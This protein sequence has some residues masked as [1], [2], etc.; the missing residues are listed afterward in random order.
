[1]SQPDPGAASQRPH[2][3]S[4]V[5]NLFLQD[6]VRGAQESTRSRLEVVVASPGETPASALAAAGVFLGAPV[7]AS[8]VEDARMRWSAATHFRQDEDLPAVEEVAGPLPAKRW[9]RGPR[10]RRAVSC[11]HLGCLGQDKLG[12]LE[13]V[14]STRPL[15]GS[16]HGGVDYLVWCLLHREVGLMV[17]AY[18]L[19]RLAEVLGPQQVRVLI[20]PDSWARAGLP[21]WL[22]EIHA[23]DINRWSSEVFKRTR[24]QVQMVCGPIA[25]AA[26]AVGGV[27]NLARG[28]VTRDSSQSLWRK[29][30]AEMVAGGPPQ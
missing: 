28:L 16:G 1:M 27:D 10:S 21:G 3:I 23:E 14:A 11:C 8:L 6:E 29:L 18:L 19:G 13:A 9:E 26:D 15:N 12:Y 17:P 5:A 25:V 30:G 24:D 2:H 7:G 22:D 4:S 20:F